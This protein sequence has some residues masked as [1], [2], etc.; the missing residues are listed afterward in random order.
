[1]SRIEREIDNLGRVVIPMEF[2]K[3][4][5]IESNSKVFVS[6]ENDTIILTPT[7]KYCALCGERIEKIRKLRICDGCV[8]KIKMD[9]SV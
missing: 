8:L 4:L 6:L 1:M 7:K 3:K 9:E 5:A 2:R